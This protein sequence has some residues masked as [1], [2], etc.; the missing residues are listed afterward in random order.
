MKGPGGPGSLKGERRHGPPFPEPKEIPR[1]RQG[2]EKAVAA[3]A[4]A[5]P[6]V[7]VLV[8]ADPI[9]HYNINSTVNAHVSGN[10]DG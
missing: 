1:R 4:D 7:D 6:S 3:T 2:R 10:I 8:R 5:Q 9:V